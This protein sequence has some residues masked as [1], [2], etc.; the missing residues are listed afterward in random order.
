LFSSAAPSLEIHIPISPTTAMINMARALTLSLRRNGGI[1]R[2]APV[3]L[4]VGAETLQAD[5]PAALPWLRPLGVEWRWLPPTEFSR[6]TFWT[7]AASRYGQRFA[8]TMVLMLDA[9]VLI[10]APFDDMVRSAHR[11]SALAALISFASPFEHHRL[12]GGW[13][14]LFREFGLAEPRLEFTHTGYGSL[15][16][17]PNFARCP[18]YFNQGVVCLPAT[19]ATRMGEILPSLMADVKALTDTPYRLQLAIA[20]AVAKLGAPSLALPLRYNFPNLEPIET[21]HRREIRSA[22]LLHLHGSEPVSKMD[23]FASAEAMKAFTARADL[24][25]VN[26]AARQVLAAVLPQMS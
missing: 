18:A 13:Y 7:T 23:L 16:R 21:R 14:R 4:T 20:L 2:N 24:T 1:Y 11:Q 26:A 8:S 19:L 15:H 6:D 3:I 10:A 22:S 12:E 9:D 5:L 25:G 17:D